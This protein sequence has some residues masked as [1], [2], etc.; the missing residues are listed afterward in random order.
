MGLYMAALW[1]WSTH[2]LNLQRFSRFSKYKGDIIK[3]QKSPY[4]PYS[5]QYNLN[6]LISTLYN[7]YTCTGGAL[8][9]VLFPTLN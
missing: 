8:Q 9:A 6:L 1:Y 4:L 3:G 5:V 2:Q 7:V